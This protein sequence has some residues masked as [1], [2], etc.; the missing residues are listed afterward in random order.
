MTPLEISILLH[1]HVSPTDYRGGDFSAPAV[2]EAIDRFVDSVLLIQTDGRP[3][4]SPLYVI[5]PGGRR[6]AEAFTRVPLLTDMPGFGFEPPLVARSLD[7]LFAEHQLTPEER[8][9]LVVYLAT[10]RAMATLRALGAG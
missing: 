3:D 2:R 6:Q 10:L 9:Q 8:Q 1:Y 4:A 5:S 7:A